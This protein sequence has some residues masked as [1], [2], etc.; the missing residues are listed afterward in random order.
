MSYGLDQGLAVGYEN[1]RMVA[2]RGG[3]CRC[4]HGHR[5]AVA[6]LCALEGAPRVIR[7]PE[8][9]TSTPYSSTARTVS[10]TLTT[11]TLYH[12]QWQ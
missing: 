7:N 2:S 11:S 12:H 8:I 1:E 3:H 9:F 10:A 4:S 6:S 5:Y